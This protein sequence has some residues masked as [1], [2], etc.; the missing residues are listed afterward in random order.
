MKPY[1]NNN[2]GIPIKKCCASC[3]YKRFDNKNRLCV[4]GEGIV[5]ATY[6]CRQWRMSPR[7]FNVGKGDGRIK[8]REYLMYA[9]N[10]QLEEEANAEAAN[11]ENVHYRKSTLGEIRREFMS[12]N[13]SIFDTIE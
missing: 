8:K 11:N 3:D 1:E 10:R 9:L 4:L 12:R 7:L 6:V 13:K 5:P 2:M